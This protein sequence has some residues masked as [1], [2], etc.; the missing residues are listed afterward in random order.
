ML[1]VCGWEFF[2]DSVALLN[3]KK[4]SVNVSVPVMLIADVLMDML[5]GQHKELKLGGCWSNLRSHHCSLHFY[6]ALLPLPAPCCVV[7]FLLAT[8]FW[9]CFSN[10]SPMTTCVFV[11]STYI[12]NT[13]HD[14]TF[15]QAVFYVLCL[16]WRR[17]SSQ[18]FSNTPLHF[19][20]LPGTVL[21]TETFIGIVVL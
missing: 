6:L 20:F 10:S 7:V 21:Q 3:W 2:C 19:S 9:R 8:I 5:S 13:V 15:L 11:E 1:L 4:I 17:D 14:E 16:H 12:N 18:R